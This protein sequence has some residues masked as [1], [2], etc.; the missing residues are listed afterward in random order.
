MNTILLERPGHFCAIET[1]PPPAPEPKQ[2]TVRI[3]RVGI[4]GT[5]YHAFRGRQ[6]FFEYPRILGHELSGEVVRVGEEVTHVKP[7]DR[8][9]IEPYLNCG[10]CVACRRGKANCCTKLAVFGVQT[11]GGMREL[12][13]LPAHKLYPSATL[14]L[15]QLAI[16]ETLCIGAHAVDRAGLAAGERVLVIGAGPIGLTVITFAGL[17]G[18]EVTVMELN[19]QRRDF[20]REHLGITQFVDGVDGVADRLEVMHGNLPTAVFDATGNA[21]SMESAFEYV[22]HGGKLIFV[23]L[24]QGNLT[25]D[26]PNFHRRELTL[27]SSRNATPDDFRRVLDALESGRINV[28]PWITHRA[29]AA[30]LIDTFPRWLAPETGVVKAVVEF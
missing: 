19:P 4:C 23:G 6:P 12:V 14:P 26:D 13:T 30:E 2:A 27:F 10:E 15:E 24:V 16:V 17:A 1:E 3:R 28:A 18:A 8:V 7:G 25:F 29:T 20:C 5:D 11:D 21:Q 9:A 22:A